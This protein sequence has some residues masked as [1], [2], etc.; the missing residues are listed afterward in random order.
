MP[1]LS[2]MMLIEIGA[3]AA[4]LAY[5]LFLIKEKIICWSF[6]IVGSLL[7]VYLFMDARL[8]SEALLYVFYAVMG[9]WGWLRWHRRLEQADNPVIRWQLAAHLKATVI[10]CSAALGMGLLA[11][12]FSNAERPFFDA[13]T[14]S[15]SFL[16]TYLEIVKVLEA[17]GYWF[18][19]NLASVWL[20][21]DRSLDI[22]AVLI[23]IYSILSIWGFLEWRQSYRNQTPT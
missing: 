21:H 6:G 22:Y 15:F 2:T 10:A 4:N 19:L 16:A 8:Y 3:T 20:Y 1:E 5:L 17:W 9:C 13:F 23:G 11:H 12:N 7:S 18:I 14:S